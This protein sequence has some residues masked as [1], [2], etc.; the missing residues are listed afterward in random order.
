MEFEVIFG[1]LMLMTVLVGVARRSSVPYPI[2]LVLAGSMV[3]FIPGLPKVEVEPELVFLLFLPPILTFSAYNMPLRDFRRLLRPILLLAVGLVV[4]T[5][6][7]VG[8]VAHALIPGLPLAAAFALGAIIAPTDAIAATSIAERLGLPK[9]IVTILEGESLINDASALTA[10]RF[11]VAATLSGSF[12]LGAALQEFVLLSLGGIVVGLLLGL[13][14]VLVLHWLDDAPVEILLTFVMSFI[15]YLLA[16]RLHVSGVLAAVLFGAVVSWFS[17]RVMTPSVRIEGG[18]AWSIV[19]FLI[20]SLAFLLLGL[21]LPHIIEHLK[22]AEVQTLVWQGLLLGLVVMVVRI[23]WVFPSAYLP[24][25]L[26]K[27]EININPI[28]PFSNLAVIA[29]AGMRGIVSLAAS[30]SL[31]KDF[32]MREELIFLTFILV[33]ITL[34][35]QGLSMVPIIN[36]LKPQKSDHH[37]REE[38]WARLVVAQAGL[39][40]LDLLASEDWTQPAHIEQFKLAYVRRRERFAARFWGRQHQE[41]EEGAQYYRRLRQELMEAEMKALIELRDN[42]TINDEVMRNIQYEMD[43]EQLRR[44]NSASA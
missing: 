21:Q 18:A 5:T 9:R 19:I 33:M 10:Y 8:L 24:R 15:A 16:E 35:G 38:N 44:E 22:G 37:Q 2:F 17:A 34:V 3:G 4:F 7:I 13:L 41:H 27:N 25:L 11:A 32:P 30:L 26:S 1:V 14:M 42:G 40:Q 23:V 28:P 31:P 20:N 6:L 36:W 29:W 12:S 43:L 39:A